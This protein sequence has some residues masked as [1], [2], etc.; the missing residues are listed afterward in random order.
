MAICL[1]AVAHAMPKPESP[2]RSATAVFAGG[3]FWYL[4]AAFDQVPGVVAT[5]SGYMDRPADMTTQA[6][7][8]PLQVVQVT[9]DPTQVTYSALLEAFWQNVDPLDHGGQFC[10]RG[11]QY[12]SAVLV[13]GPVQRAAAEASLA[14]VQ[15]ALAAPVATAILPSGEFRPAPEHQQNYHRNHPLRFRYQRWRCHRKARLE[16]LWGTRSGT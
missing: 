2:A 14:E 13:N 11:E 9:F 12:Q 3:R 6:S 7:A 15:A 16:Q 5:L 1:A 10:E 4:E 8:A